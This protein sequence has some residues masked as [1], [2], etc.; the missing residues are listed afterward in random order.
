MRNKLLILLLIVSSAL[1]V[2]F[3]V[4]AAKKETQPTEKIVRAQFKTDGTVILPVNYHQWVHVGTFIKESGI[5]IFDNSTIT[6]PLIGNTYIEPSAYRYYMATGKWA[7]GSQIV[8]EFT[9]ALTGYNCD[10]KNTHICKTAIGSGIY[11]NNYAGFGYMVKDKTRYPDEAGNWAFFTS[12]HL[13]PPYPETARLKDKGSCSAC[14][15]TH[16]SDQ[17]YVFAAQKIGLERNNPANK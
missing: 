5:N 8:K 9:E 7:D 10:N 15:I 14:H 13:K 2:L 4:Q 1:S 16:A 3:G 6:A 17:D 11:Q 12:G